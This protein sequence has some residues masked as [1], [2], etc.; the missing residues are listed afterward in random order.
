MKVAILTNGEI[1]DYKFY[2]S[3]IDK[4]D[5][6]ICADGGLK[7]AFKM[8]AHPQV[9]LGDF[10]ST[11][12]HIVD[13]FSS[14]G[15][16]IKK[17]S[18]IKNETDTEIALQYAMG[19]RPSSIDILAG[20]GDRID[21]SLANIHLLKQALDA[22]IKCKIITESHE[23]IACDSHVILYGGTGDGVSLLPLTET[24]TGVYTKGLAYTVSDGRFEIGS[25]YGISNYMSES[26]AEIRIGGGI[27]LVIRYKE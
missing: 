11:P 26:E 19:K 25:P 15:T 23:I 27:L 17:Y 18:T 24:V 14:R 9:A 4:Y 3:R 1:L 22:N 20:L 13:L 7:H 12:G 6:I 8:D 21:H 10:D 5:L 16:K 2:E